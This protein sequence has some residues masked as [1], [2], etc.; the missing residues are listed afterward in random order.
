MAPGKRSRVLIVVTSHDRLGDSG[1]AT[2]FWLEELSTPYYALIDA[3]IEVDI[4]SIKGGV[5]PVDPKSEQ[6][7]WKT[8][9]A[10]RFQADAKA[11]HWLE[12]TLKLGTLRSEDYDA[13][14]L[15]GGHGTMWDFPTDPSL[16]KLLHD[17]NRTGK[18]IASVCHGVAALVPLQ[19]AQGRPLVAGRA[20]TSFTDA[21]ERAVQLDAIVP[22]LLESRL[23]ELGA[24]FESGPDW[25]PKVVR[26]GNL[27]TGQNPASAAPA[28]QALID[29][30][31][32][33]TRTNR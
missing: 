1:A 10:I 9:S 17:F 19:D 11:A 32:A 33:G 31:A 27:I 29:A 2:G 26:D 3:G 6:D 24:R 13:V 15:A 5:A 16:A 30:L 8:E 22:F 7:E 18:L 25:D 12:N 20:L 23:R 28:S 4:A 21:E 14:Y